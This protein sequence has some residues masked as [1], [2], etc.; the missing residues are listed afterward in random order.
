MITGVLKQYG[1]LPC[2]HPAKID[3]ELHPDHSAHRLKYTVALG[4]PH[5]A[6]IA[7]SSPDSLMHLTCGHG[8]LLAYCTS[9]SLKLLTITEIK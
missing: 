9:K 6:E 7:L 5:Q 2:H 4:P 1:R 8:L 3:S